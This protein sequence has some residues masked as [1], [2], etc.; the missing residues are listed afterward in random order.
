MWLLFLRASS[1]GIKLTWLHK[2]FSRSRC[3]HD[4]GGF[5]NL[6]AERH[7]QTQFSS[8]RLPAPCQSKSSSGG[9]EKNGHVGPGGSR[10]AV[11]PFSNFFKKSAQSQTDLCCPRHCEWVGEDRESVSRVCKGEHGDHTSVAVVPKCMP[12][13]LELVVSTGLSPSNVARSCES[14]EA[15]LYLAR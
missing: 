4:Q 13:L 8:D 6:H 2:S 3:R 5:E 11:S 15:L 7:A 1:D 9:Q 12:A 10:R 14:S